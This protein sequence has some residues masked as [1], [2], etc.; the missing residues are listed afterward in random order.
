MNFKLVV[1]RLGS[2]LPEC[3]VRVF[4]RLATGKTHVAL[5]LHR[6]CE[7]HRPTDPQPELA[8]PASTLDALLKLFKTARPVNAHGK[9]WLSV[10]FDDGYADAVNYVASRAQAHSEV[11]WLAFVCPVK[12]EKQVGFRWDLFESLQ[13]RGVPHASLGTI[14]H[15]NPDVKLENERADLRALARD[16]SF[17]LASL[18]ACLGLQAFSNAWLGNHTN[19]H[20]RQAGLNPSCARHELETSTSDFERLFGPCTHFAFPFG[21]PRQEFLPEHVEILRELG[22]FLI[23]TT[24]ARPFHPEE[25]VPQAVLPRFPVNGT[26]SAKKIAFWI[27]LLA[28]KFRIARRGFFMKP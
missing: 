28:L 26:W 27:A 7:S 17:E 5:C 9:P 23:W 22:S 16:P 15:S 1:V 10:S 13:T 4:V 19:T 18:E 3:L 6:V 20:L 8:I 2:Y 25:R 24:E 14:V 12:N 21:T 11:E